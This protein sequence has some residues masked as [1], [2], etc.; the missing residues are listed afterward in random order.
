MIYESWKIKR[1]LASSI[2]VVE[3]YFSFEKKF[4]NYEMKIIDKCLKFP[5]K[6]KS[7]RNFTN[8]ALIKSL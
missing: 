6:K 7:K 4:L 2:R 8:S 3:D 5:V 1:K